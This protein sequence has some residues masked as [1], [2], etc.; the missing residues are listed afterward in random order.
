MKIKYHTET[1]ENSDRIFQMM[2]NYNNIVKC[3][4]NY[5]LKNPKASTAEIS[6][7]QNSLNNIFLDTH[8]KCSAIYNA[9]Q[10]ININGENKVIFGGKKL[11]IQRC[12]NKILK[13]EFYKQKQI[14]IYRIG[15]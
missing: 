11:F 6:K 13:E 4:Y 9:K 10:L 5:L 3:T 7:Y 14:P 15:Q 2:I 1:K 8:F 12:Q